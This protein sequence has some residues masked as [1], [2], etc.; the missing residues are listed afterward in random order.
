MSIES[1]SFI[2]FRGGSQDD[3]GITIDSLNIS[4]ERK[5][6]IE[7]LRSRAF[8]LRTR[9]NILIILIVCLLVAGAVVVFYA[10]QTQSC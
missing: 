1:L 2:S 9:S 4:K 5:L 8:S 6:I 10:G 7:E 3:K